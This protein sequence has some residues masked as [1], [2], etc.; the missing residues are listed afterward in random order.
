MIVSSAFGSSSGN[1]CV[2]SALDTLV[3]D[4]T[5]AVDQRQMRETLWEVPDMPSC[6]WVV[7]FG[8]QAQMIPDRKQTFEQL[9]GF[10]LSSL[11]GVVVGKP[12]AACEERTLISGKAVEIL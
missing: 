5:S 3:L 1:K 4:H 6:D 12:K 2:W 8:K 11:K 7:L 10:V 9:Y